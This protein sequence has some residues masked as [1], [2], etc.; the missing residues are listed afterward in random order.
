MVQ[1]I[2]S[3]LHGTA[4]E[5][6]WAGTSVLLTSTV[7]Q[8]IWASLSHIIDP[9]SVLMVAM[10]IF[11][12]GSVVAVVA[13]NWRWIFWLN[14]PLCVIGQAGIPICLRLHHRSGEGFDTLKHFDWVG[15]VVFVGSMTSF[16]IPLTGVSFMKAECSTFIQNY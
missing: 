11:T 6:F 2:A 5:V 13:A 15:S 1:T 9:K 7:F 4:I 10:F 16:L 8:P 14:L 12:I 3:D